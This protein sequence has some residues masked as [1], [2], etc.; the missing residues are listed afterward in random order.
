MPSFE[1]LTIARSSISE[2]GVTSAAV[3]VRN[4]SSAA[5]SSSGPNDRMHAGTPRSA[6]SSRTEERVIPGRMLEVSSLVVRT[7]SLTKKTFSPEASATVP[8][9]FRRIASIAPFVAASCA[10]RIELV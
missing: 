7:P 6:A 4:T 5:S 3:P 2:T 10:A 1:C 8:S 9:A